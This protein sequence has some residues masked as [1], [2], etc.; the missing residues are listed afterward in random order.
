MT[1]KFNI[2]I[3][4][5]KGLLCISLLYFLSFNT[6]SIGN[7]GFSLIGSKKES[8]VKFEQIDNLI[9]VPIQ[10]N[11]GQWTKAVVDTGIRSVVLY[12]KKFRKQLNIMDSRDVKIN[13]LGKGRRQQGKLAID[14]EVRIGDVLGEGVA[15]VSVDGKIPFEIL[16][17]NGVEAILGYQLFNRF[18]IEI[19]YLNNEITFRDPDLFI[20]NPNAHHFGI[21]VIDTKPYITTSIKI[22]NEHSEI[23]AHEMKVLLDTGA[24][25]DMMIYNG[26]KNANLFTLDKANMGAIGQ[27]INGEIGGYS[28]TYSNINIGDIH[29]ESIS[30]SVAVRKTNKDRYG[31]KHGIDGLIG[32]NVLK[33]FKVTFDYINGDVYL[34]EPGL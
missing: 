20:A 11:N 17:K 32:G 1:N 4:S 8:K 28:S 24:A 27:G 13:G 26:S 12:G 34:E 2:S 23:I 3:T 31:K 18:I 14:N 7:V 19:D 9:V 10:L 30:V 29:L 33:H 5:C 22:R 25:L 16:N 15:I 6:Y 21:E